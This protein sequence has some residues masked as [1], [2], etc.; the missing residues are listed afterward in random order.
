M[1]AVTSGLKVFAEVLAGLQQK[2]SRVGTTFNS[3]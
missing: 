1:R 3:C 2:A